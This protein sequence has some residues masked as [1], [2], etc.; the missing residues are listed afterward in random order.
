MFNWKFWK[1]KGNTFED[2]P[3]LIG[4]EGKL[5]QNA[6]ASMRKIL[7]GQERISLQFQ[8]MFNKSEEEKKWFRD[9]ID[10]V[11]GLKRET[12]SSKKD[13]A[14]TPLISLNVS[15]LLCKDEEHILNYIHTYKIE[16]HKELIIR[17]GRKLPEIQNIVKNL[18]KKG[19]KLESF[20]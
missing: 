12:S 20:E 11:E 13:I 9:I 4:E 16:T 3:F 7:E 10:S 6:Y 15:T 8:A 19:H 14:E 2:V 1:K 5:I 17:T 18:R